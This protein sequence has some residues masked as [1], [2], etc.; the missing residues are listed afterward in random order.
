MNNKYSEKLRLNESLKIYNDYDDLYK[1]YG[2]LKTTTDD[3]IVLNVMKKLNDRSLIGLTKYNT[4]LNNSNLPLKDWL[5][6]LQEE[7]LDACNYIEKILSIID[8]NENK[9]F[10]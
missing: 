7:L 5:I 3:E 9:I 6:H 1:I 4:S 8:V 10:D 2:C